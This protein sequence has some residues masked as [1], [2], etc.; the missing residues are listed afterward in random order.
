MGP[1]PHK[2]GQVVQGQHHLLLRS[3]ASCESHRVCTSHEGSQGHLPAKLPS[4]LLPP[5]RDA[6]GM[7][8]SCSFVPPS[9][10]L[11]SSG[12]TDRCEEQ[13]LQMPPELALLDVPLPRLG[14]GTPV[15]LGLLLSSQEPLCCTAL[16]WLLLPQPTYKG[17]VCLWL[18]IVGGIL[19]PV[20]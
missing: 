10:S 14:S 12:A 18:V 4:L 16:N 8:C 20:R 19:S 13:T 15:A 11:L 3:S 5:S 2:G 1:T 9:V 6:G 7:P 17:M